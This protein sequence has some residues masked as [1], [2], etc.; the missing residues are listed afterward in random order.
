M[1]HRA[2]CRLSAVGLLFALTPAAWA[3]AAKAPQCAQCRDTGRVPCPLHDRASA[4]YQAFCSACPEPACCKGVGW[5]PCPR[6]ADEAT[7]KRFDAVAALYAKEREGSGFYP[8]GAD[9]LRTASEHFRFK[10]AAAPHKE[11]HEYHAAAEKAFSLFRKVFGEQAV[12]ELK[13]D[14]KGHFLILAS[15]EQYHKF[16]DWYYEQHPNANANEKDFL[17]EGSG[18]RMIS[19]RLQV[20]IG[21]PAYGARDDKDS[22]LHRIAHAAGHLAIEN[23]KVHGNTPDWLDEGWAARSEIEA[24][25]EPQVY[26]VEYS[27]PGVGERKPKEWRQIVREA[28]RAKKAPTLEKL[29]EMKVGDMHAVEWATALSLVTWLLEQGQPSF[30][31]MV[32]AIKDGQA[33]KAAVEAAL[34]KDLA[35]IEKAWQRWALFH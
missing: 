34:G 11:C 6:C 24:L 20:L 2:W 14:E 9:F 8:Y 18:V 35:A 13:W 19:D 4:R 16:L 1:S 22:L 30:A 12:D 3:A 29:F 15:R 26:C 7:R 23:H 21:D 28:L 5:K 10:A 32:D 17:R 33:S 27:S 31:R 25:R